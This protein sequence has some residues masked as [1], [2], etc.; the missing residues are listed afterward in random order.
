[1]SESEEYSF[2]LDVLC[3]LKEHYPQ[4]NEK[5]LQQL[6]EIVKYRIECR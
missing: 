5:V 4:H 6:I 1:M 2:I 3:D